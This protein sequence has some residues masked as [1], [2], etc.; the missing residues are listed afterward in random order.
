MKKTRKRRLSSFEKTLM[1]S[2]DRMNAF[3]GERLRRTIW[4]REKHEKA[5][6]DY[7]FAN[8]YRAGLECALKAVEEGRDITGASIDKH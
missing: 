2:H 1:E 8:G 4:L 6:A 3:L 7:N 5:V